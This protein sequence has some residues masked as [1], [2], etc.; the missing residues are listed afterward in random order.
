MIRNAEPAE[1]EVVVELTRFAYAEFESVMTPVTWRGL[2]NAIEAVFANSGPAEIIVA[3]NGDEIVGSVFLYPGG[4]PP[5]PGEPP[6]AEPEFRLLSVPRGRRGHG[7]G[8]A[9]VEEC[10]RRSKTAGA[11]ALGLHTSA[12]F[13]DAIALYRKMG[14]VRTPERDF[15]PTDAEVVEA[16]RLPLPSGVR[17]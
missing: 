10:I 13:R 17:T 2:S 12:S 3:A 7:V 11:K 6:L 8:R 16:Y 1:R 5:Y 14:F 4:S 9:L 15:R